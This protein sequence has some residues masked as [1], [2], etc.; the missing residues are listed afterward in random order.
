MNISIR[1]VVLIVALANLAYFG[2]EFAVA[3]RIGSVSLLADSADFF[4]DASVNLL[5]FV[6]MTWTA[7]SRARA[8][9]IM[10]I[11][12]LAPALAFLWTAWQKFQ[13]PVPPQ[14][15]ALSLTGFGAL[16]V[17]LF[18]AYL[19]AAFRDAHGSLTKA[20]FLSARNDAIA[21]IGIIAAGAV[22]LYVWPTPWPDLIVGFGI[23][24]MNLD[25]AKEVWS[26]AREEHK[27]LA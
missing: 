14:P 3:L 12:L 8:G 16:A 26:A 4:E 1:R 24:W 17:N 7:K 25:A 2:V 22:T 5:I 11:I 27:A 15:L 18:C 20:A 21:N 23:A 6:A 9:M 10:S 13:M 19:L